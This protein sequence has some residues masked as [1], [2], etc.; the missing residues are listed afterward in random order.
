MV[1]KFLK[2]SLL[3]TRK[4]K[5]IGSIVE[6]AEVKFTKSDQFNLI[7]STNLNHFKSTRLQV[8]EHGQ[9]KIAKI[10]DD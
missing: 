9:A 3:L 6:L 5:K 8:P 4:M 10:L 1:G 7:P 2:C